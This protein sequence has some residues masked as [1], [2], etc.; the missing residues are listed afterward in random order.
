[1]SKR[2]LAVLI[3]CFTTI[4][5]CYAIRYSYGMILPE[6]L[7]SLAISKTEAGVIF[8]S[9]FIAYT[10]SSPILGLLADRYNVRVLLTLFPLI[11]GAGAFLMSRS[12]SLFQASSFFTLA[13]IGSGACWAPVMGLAQRWISEKR[14]GLS[15]AF[16]DVGSALGFTTSSAF[17]P[18][19]VVAYGWRTGWVAL[20][21][22][23]LAAGSANFFLVR[24]SPD[25]K[26][27]RL[28][29]MPEKPA[30]E[31]IIMIYARL[32]GDLKFWLL[33]LSYLLIGFSIIVPFTFLSTYAV[34][35][36]DLPYGT[37]ARLITI[38]GITAI[39]G[40]IVLGPISDKIGRIKVIMLCVALIG[41]GCFGIAFSERLITLIFFTMSFGLGYGAIWSMYAASASDYFS[42]ESAGTIMGFWIVYLGT[43]SILSPIIA[44]WVGDMTGTLSYSFLLAALSATIALFLLLPVWKTFRM[45]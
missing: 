30:R 16:I 20:S 17:V 28:P 31:P 11:L 23:A 9:Y 14:R 8:S 35:E 22:L 38:I 25:E 13:G 26:H 34:Q 41:T 33:A 40:K 32:L 45:V 15:L 10:I 21:T 18:L 12:E 27:E 5:A 2:T 24:S 37:A 1:M 36:L 4:F 3:S 44:G 6:M 43:G 7:P 42:K 39:I 19:I 29:S